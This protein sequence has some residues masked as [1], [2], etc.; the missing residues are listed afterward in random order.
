M[1]LTFQEFL[2]LRISFERQ[3]LL[4]RWIDGD[5]AVMVH[6][7]EEAQDVSCVCAN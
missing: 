1:L 7:A 4:L 3:E 5:V 2:D 6:E